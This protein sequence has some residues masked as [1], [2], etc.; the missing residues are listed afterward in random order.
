[1][2]GVEQSEGSAGPIRVAWRN[3]ECLDASLVALPRAMAAAGGCAVRKMLCGARI[4]RPAR[5]GYR[6]LLSLASPLL[7]CTAPG[8]RSPRRAPSKSAVF[9]RDCQRARAFHTRAKVVLP[10]LLV[11]SSPYTFASGLSGI[12]FVSYCDGKGEG[13]RRERA[14]GEHIS[15][16]GIGSG[17]RGG[18]LKPPKPRMRPA[19][20][21]SAGGRTV[22]ASGSRSP[23][24]L[25]AETRQNTHFGSPTPTARTFSAISARLSISLAQTRPA[26]SEE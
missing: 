21:C 18:S 5:L 13:G 24:P 3:G 23:G 6:R 9:R 14:S 22:P 7:T 1:M 20:A 12:T 16:V 2:R 26:R 10:S 17:N 15:S 11:E 4:S 19:G 25:Q 8:L